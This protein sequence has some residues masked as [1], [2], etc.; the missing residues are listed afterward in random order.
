MRR[1]ALR[2]LAVAVVAVT[3]GCGTTFHA[4]DFVDGQENRHLIVGYKQTLF[5]P[6]LQLWVLDEGGKLA[7]VKM[8][9]EGAK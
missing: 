7:E 5:G 9:E 1:L 3:A 6:R 2:A 8:V 4:S